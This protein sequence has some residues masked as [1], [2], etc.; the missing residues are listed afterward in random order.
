[1]SV[2]FPHLDGGPYLANSSPFKNTRSIQY[3]QY[4]KLVID[5]HTISEPLQRGVHRS[6]VLV[7]D[8]ALKGSHLVFSSSYNSGMGVAWPFS[9]LALSATATN[10][11]TSCMAAVAWLLPA[12]EG[13]RATRLSHPLTSLVAHLASLFVEQRRGRWGC[14]VGLGLE[15]CW[16]SQQFTSL[17]CS[18]RLGY[19]EGGLLCRGHDRVKNV[20]SDHASDVLQV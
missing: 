8:N 17:L 5:R 20:A 18:Q 19:S 12:L 10:K 15:A 14:S 2:S 9:V 7:V 4:S 1:M 16:R 11:V 13:T 3:T 6:H